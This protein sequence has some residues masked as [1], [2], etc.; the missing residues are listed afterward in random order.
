MKKIIVNGGCPLCGDVMVSGSK[1]ASLPII[2]ACILTNGVSRIGNLPDIG[3]VRVALDIIRDFGAVVEKRED[4]VYVDTR[5]LV[6][7]QPRPDLVSGIRAST[8]LIGSCLGR[9]GRCRIMPFGGCN[10]SSRP[11]DM[12]IS[13][14]CAMGAEDMDGELF[15]HR[16]TGGVIHFDKASVGATV[17]AILLASTAEGKSELHGCATEPHIDTLID[18]LNSC[19]GAII[20]R[21][22]SVYVEGRELHGGSISINGDMIEAGSYIALGLSTGGCISLHNCPTSEMQAPIDAFSALG[23][24][25]KIEDPEIV[26]AKMQ[27][28][29]YSS[30]EALPYP[31][32]P[33]DLQ[34]VIAP[35]MAAHGGDITDSVWPSRFGYL[36]ALSEF[37][38]ESR[39][40]NKRAYILPS[41]LHRGRAFAPDLRGGMACLIAALSTDGESEIHSAENLLR[42]YENLEKKLCALGAEI[43]IE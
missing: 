21:G 10:F 37:G 33:T 25:I 34:P 3:D 26:T 15:A 38:I 30:V 23:A 31:G 11:I 16:L 29:R 5:E 28:G 4:A 39:L 14:A 18:F 36:R 22:R 24:D 43:K 13:A 27:G 20:R 42:G 8:Y 2:F 7:S 41:R 19:G 6:Y 17:N 1:N 9:F 12:H 40:E 35:V 32:F